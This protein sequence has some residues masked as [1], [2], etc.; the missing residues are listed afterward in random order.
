MRRTEPRPRLVVAI[1]VV[2]AVLLAVPF[3]GLLIAAPWSTLLDRLTSDVVAD[4]LT[5][6]LFAS[7]LAT[8]LALFLGVPLGWW[9]ART[10][11]PVVPVV[12]A[13]AT[14]PIVVPPVV[15]GAALLFALGRRGFVGEPL[16]AATGLVLPFSIWAVVV[17]NT[18]VAVPFVVLTIEGAVRTA[19]L[20][21]EDAAATLGASP[22]QVFTRITLPALRSALW[23]AGLLAWARAFGEFGATI[24]FAGNLQG[25]TQSLPL[26]VFVALE[27]DRDTAIA[28]SLLMMLVSA[29]VLVVLR[30]RWWSR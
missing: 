5:L 20:G 29:V 23:A 24:T 26:A 8:V 7:L 16:E 11:G 17:A 19:D 9:L 15:G 25:R 4:A 27:S 18:F 6:S 3:V 13:V 22:H 28:I 2:A 21:V 12:R 14:L 10:S 1:A 30:D